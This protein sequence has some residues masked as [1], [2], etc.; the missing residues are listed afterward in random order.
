MPRDF[1]LETAVCPVRVTVSTLTRMK[2]ALDGGGRV[3]WN[4]L[5]LRREIPK[6][7]VENVLDLAH[8]FNARTPHPTLDRVPKSALM[9]QWDQTREL[10][11]ESLEQGSDTAADKGGTAE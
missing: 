4:Y 6:E 11:E 7:I 3:I 10:P 8:D 2:V 1:E 9:F 5:G